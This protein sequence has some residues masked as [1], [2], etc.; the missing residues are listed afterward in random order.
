MEGKDVPYMYLSMSGL[1]L[2]NHQNHWATSGSMPS[3][4]GSREGV[5]RE[6]YEQVSQRD[7]C[8]LLG[9]VPHATDISSKKALY[10][11]RWLF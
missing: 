2:R 4:N 9:S 11:C 3:C 5:D 1:C 8:A 6:H 7:C 10:L